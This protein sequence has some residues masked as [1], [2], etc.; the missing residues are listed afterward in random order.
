LPKEDFSQAI[1]NT[2]TPGDEYAV[3][4]DY[5]PTTEYM[6]TEEFESLGCK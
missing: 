1:Q 3:M 4:G 6:S 5:L 2:S